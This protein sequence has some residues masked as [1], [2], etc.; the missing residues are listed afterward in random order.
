MSL[1]KKI[2]TQEKKDFV[3][4]LNILVKSGTPID[5]AFRLLSEQTRSSLLK[6]VF[7]KAR[8]RTEKGT[9]IYQIF[10]DNPNFEKVFSSFIRAGEESGTL[11]NNLKNLVKWLERKQMLEMELSSATLYPKIIL[12]FSIFLG[13]GLTFFV[14]PKL[15]PIFAALDVKLPLPSRILLVTAAFIQNYGLYLIFGIIIFLIFAYLISKI[16][17]VKVKIDNLVLKIPVLGDFI[18]DYQLTIISQLFYTLFE[19]GLMITKIIDIIAESTTNRTFKKSLEYAKTRVIK[20]DPLSMVLNEFP[21]L[22]PSIYVGMITTGEETGALIESFG[23]LADFF[24]TS[25]ADKTK[26]LPI[27]LEPVILIL[28]GLFVAFIAS[29]VILPIYQITQG[30]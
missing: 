18:R 29:A 6:E 14:L 21:Q 15:V 19:S 23:Y 27:I 25:I 5:E 28:I 3:K 16:E 10:E 12:I 2:S 7:Q 13:G 30:F 4:T 1:F 9:P 24:S 11:E 8:E 22:Y 17:K 26:K 20:G